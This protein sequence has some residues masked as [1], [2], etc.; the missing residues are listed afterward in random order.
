MGLNN[1]SEGFENNEFPV[2]DGA[3][4]EAPK[5][6]VG[7]GAAIAGVG[8]GVFSRT[9]AGL[10]VFPKR[11][12]EEAPVLDPKLPKAAG[13]AA[14]DVAPLTPLFAPKVKDDLLLLL[15]S[16]ALPNIAGV[17]VFPLPKAKEEGLLKLSVA[18]GAGAG[19]LLGAP[20]RKLGFGVAKGV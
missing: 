19:L 13:V 14:G 3:G 12:A 1:G 20:K 4:D 16:P 5:E 6:N 8:S 7:W 10:G 18:G 2:D 11:G 17:F 15:L 9:G